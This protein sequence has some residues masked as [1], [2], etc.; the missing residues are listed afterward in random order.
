M[1]ITLPECEGRAFLIV[2][3]TVFLSLLSIEML[4]RTGN[5]PPFTLSK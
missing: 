3:D 5:G 4:L 2:I 1:N